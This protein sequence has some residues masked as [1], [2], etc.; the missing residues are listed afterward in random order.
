MPC[1]G[2]CKGTGACGCIEQGAPDDPCEP[3]EITVTGAGTTASPFL[4]TPETHLDRIVSTDGWEPWQI[5]NV[6]GCDIITPRCQYGDTPSVLMCNASSVLQGYA[7]QV[8]NCELGTSVWKYQALDTTTVQTSLPSGWRPCCGQTGGYAWHPFYTDGDLASTLIGY[9][10]L[11]SDVEVG[12]VQQQYVTLAGSITTS[13]PG[14][15]EQGSCAVASSGGGGG[16]G[17]GTFPDP[18]PGSIHLY[19]QSGLV[20]NDRKYPDWGQPGLDNTLRWDALHLPPGY[21]GA[22]WMRFVVTVVNV[23][24]PL[25]SALT[26]TL[27][28]L[29]NSVDVAT[30]TWPS[31]TA[32]SGGALH[33][34]LS[35]SSGSFTDWIKVQWHI[36]SAQA[37]NSFG[38]HGEA[39]Y[40]ATAGFAS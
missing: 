8:L 18:L 17:T 34:D 15:W 11:R 23:S 3:V 26:V 28:D 5:E 33:G 14:S 22:D 27:K 19:L 24:S 36:A 25:T 16:G 39:F 4:I 1:V 31:G 12:T 21:T 30:K 40:E 7:F 20:L 2:C 32:P 29:T 37:D 9:G 6:A 13:K 10:Y 35:I 38:L